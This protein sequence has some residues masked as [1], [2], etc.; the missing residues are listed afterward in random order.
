MAFLA[1]PMS[2]HAAEGF[3]GVTERGSVVRFTDA[4]PYADDSE[5][6]ERTGTGRADPQDLR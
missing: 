3:V 4:A 5:A 1:L 6:A 2:A